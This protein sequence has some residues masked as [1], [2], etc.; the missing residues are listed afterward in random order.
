MTN[1]Y[2]KDGNGKIKTNVFIGLAIAASLVAMVPAIVAITASNSTAG[3][4]ASAAPPTK[5][6]FL[7]VYAENALYEPNA[8]KTNVFG[9]GGI[10]PFFNDTFT[11]GNAITCGIN[12]KEATFKGVFKENGGPGDNQFWADYTAPITYGDQQIKNHHYRVVLQ[13]TMWNNTSAA[14]TPLPTALPPF[15]KAGKGVSF[16]QIQHGHSMID[17]ADVPMFMNQVSLYGHANVYDLT[18]GN[19]MV[20]KDIFIHLMVGKVV[21]ENTYFTNMKASPQTQTVVALFVVNIPSGVKLPGGI[22]PLTPAQA[23]S[24]TPPASDLSLNSTLPINYNQLLDQGVMAHEPAPGS[25]STI[26]P[27]DNPTQPLFFS[28]LLFTDTKTFWSPNHHVPGTQ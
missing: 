6:P 11:C 18:D 13:N 28:F 12:T 21:D 15:L 4:E 2:I 9:P 1:H 19:K 16:D 22:G 7:K 24:F 10:F 3:T 8:G 14:E 23:Q 20:A 25:Q 27:V 17:R 26:W 5:T